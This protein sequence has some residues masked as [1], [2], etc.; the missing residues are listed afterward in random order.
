LIIKQYLTSGIS[1]PD[2]LD[3]SDC[4]V[5]GDPTGLVADTTWL[6]LTLKMTSENE[7]FVQ[8]H[9]H[10]TLRFDFNLE[11]N[12]SSEF[13]SNETESYYIKAISIEDFVVFGEE[14]Q[15]K[16]FQ[17]SVYDSNGISI[18]NELNGY[19]IRIG[20]E[21]G[22]I[23]FFDVF[24]FP[25]EFIKLSLVGQTS[26]NLGN[27][28]MS[29]EEAF[30]W[31]EGDIIQYKTYHI[32]APLPETYEHFMIT[33][34]VVTSDSVH[35]YFEREYQMIYPEGFPDPS[36]SFIGIDSPLSFARDS[37][38]VNKPYN[39]AVRNSSFIEY[40][41]SDINT[42]PGHQE[43]SIEPQFIIFCESCLCYIPYDGFLTTLEGSSYAENRGVISIYDIT[44]GPP[45]ETSGISSGMIYSEI[46][47]VSCG[48]YFPL[49]MENITLENLK[50][51]PNPVSNSLKIKATF[52]FNELVVT[53]MLGQVILSRSLP[54]NTETTVDLSEVTPGVYLIEISNGN[55]FSQP[56]RILK[57]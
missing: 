33:E 29:M 18:E 16:T 46:G 38:I 25:D 19:D 34:R 47:G 45:D 13:Y 49:S 3:V 50:V 8:N 43:L 5:W 37:L 21:I 20:E 52:H 30:T 15:V 44:Y 24:H 35:I 12:D 14:D 1:N 22:L 11:L 31:D 53:D 4:T 54:R 27:Y 57:N 51:F 39:Y 48:T 6:G 42:C 40:G 7:L 26:P 56:V 10:E 9:Q 2:S 36:P 28:Q 17:I 23:Q 41:I 55:K 32:N